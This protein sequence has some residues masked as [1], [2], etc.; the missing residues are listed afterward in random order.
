MQVAPHA[1]ATSKTSKHPAHAHKHGLCRTWAM[2]C[3]VFATPRSKRLPSRTQ[4]L[5][6]RGPEPAHPRPALAFSITTACKHVAPM[7]PSTRWLTWKSLSPLMYSARG[8]DVQPA[9][10]YLLQRQGG[11]GTLRSSFI[12]PH[13][14]WRP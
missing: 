8:S 1:P 11:G 2:P 13:R 5:H 14:M 10:E 7:E 6:V 4:A 12:Q 9:Y 3:H